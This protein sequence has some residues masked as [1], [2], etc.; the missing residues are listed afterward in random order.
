[1]DDYVFDKSIFHYY[2]MLRE[3]YYTHCQ[4]AAL[5]EKIKFFSSISE[6]VVTYITITVTKIPFT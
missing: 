6:S 3:L 4:G 5:Q 1:M 2:P